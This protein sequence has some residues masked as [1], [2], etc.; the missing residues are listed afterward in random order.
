ME[1][2]NQLGRCHRAG[3]RLNNDFDIQRHANRWSDGHLKQ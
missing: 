2:G 3:E 1:R